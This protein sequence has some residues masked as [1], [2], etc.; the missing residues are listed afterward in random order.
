MNKNLILT[1]LILCL[2]A[3]YWK[4]ES[5][6]F[7]LNFQFQYAKKA[8]DS[9]NIE[10]I[11]K[12]NTIKWET[13]S[14]LG[15]STQPYADYWIRLNLKK[16]KNENYVYFKEV[17]P[18]AEYTFFEKI[19]DKWER[20]Q[21]KKRNTRLYI[22]KI[23]FDKANE[24]EVYIKA[25]SYRQR[26]LFQILEENE[27]ISFSFWETILL[28]F[29][30]GSLLSFFISNLF[31]RL[32]YIEKSYDYYLLSIVLVFFNIIITS[33]FFEQTIEY[34][35]LELSLHLM[36]LAYLL[37]TIGY[38]KF[39]QNFIKLAY[40]SPLLNKFYNYYQFVILFCCMLYC[41]DLID[42]NFFYTISRIY[43]LPIV[44]LITIFT[45]WYFLKKKSI[46][47]SKFIFQSYLIVAVVVIQ[48][49]LATAGLIP[50][51]FLSIYGSGLTTSIQLY[52]FS[53]AL[54]YK[55]E[56]LKKEKENAEEGIQMK[57]TFV[58]IISHD[59]RTPLIGVFNLL[60]I[61]SNTE[62]PKTEKEKDNLLELCATSIRNSLS[63]IKELIDI[64]K[65]NLGKFSILKKN[66]N[67]D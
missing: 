53:M 51:D 12:D 37:V 38:I 9:M 21:F 46:H 58:S 50:M 4:I 20:M 61:L 63:M 26:I 11:S 48:Q 52:L 5:R 30:I 41:F 34:Y 40:H 8:I 7:R 18:S 47:E 62:I 64:S 3:I 24:K 14:D 23:E 27:S 25:T 65:I 31:L 44:S 6:P 1:M 60:N 29:M 35:D 42:R 16:P 28:G 17:I 45:S 57:D 39:M 56:S 2:L 43:L 36:R 54:E 66:E 59:L 49:T 15:F 67:L 10:T 55:L 19:N 22:Y 13:K 33:G 32:R